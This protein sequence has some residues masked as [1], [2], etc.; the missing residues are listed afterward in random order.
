MEIN[1]HLQIQALM[2]LAEHIKIDCQDIGNKLD[3]VFTVCFKSSINDQ[4]N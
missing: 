4:R 3:E 2:S 1:I